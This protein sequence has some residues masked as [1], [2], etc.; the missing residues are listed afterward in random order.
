M[1]QNGHKSLTITLSTRVIIAAIVVVFILFTRLY[2]LDRKALMHDECMF[3]YYSWH[4]AMKGDYLYQPILH[5]PLLQNMNALMFIVLGDTTYMMRFFPA[6]CGILLFVVLYG[7]RERFDKNGMTALLVLAALSPFLMFY[8]RF[9][10]NDIPFALFSLLILFFYWKFFREGGGKNLIFAI[11][12]SVTLICI[13]EN[14]LI[15]FFTIFTFAGLLFL[16]DIIQGFTENKRLK[17]GGS[18]S[19]FENHAPVIPVKPLPVICLAGGTLITMTGIWGKLA[20]LRL[21]GFVGLVFYFALMLREYSRVLTSDKG[22]VNSAGPCMFIIAMNALAAVFFCWVLYLDL[23]SGLFTLKWTILRF[24]ALY[25]VWFVFFL[26]IALAMLRDWGREKLLK[27]FV[28]SLGEHYPYLIAGLAFSCVLYLVLFTTWFKYPKN[29]LLLYKETFEYWVGQHKEHRISGPFHYYLP[30]LA[31]YDLP[32]LLIIISGAFATLLRYR[33]VRRI[34][35]PLYAVICLLILMYFLK[36]PLSEKAWKAIYSIFHMTT[37]FHLFL[38]AT[39]SVMGTLLTVLHL[40]K[41]DRLKAFL[42]YWS[43]GSFLGYAYAGEK[44]PW[45]AVHIA[46]PLVML[47]AAYIQDFMKTGAFLR[48][49]GIWYAVFCLFAVWNL[50]SAVIVSFVNHSNIAERM[51]YSHA[52]EDVPLIAEQVKRISFE[53]G[54]REQTKILVKGWSIWPMRWYLRHY[55]WSEW[56]KPE[57]T[58]YPI[59]IMDYKD[60]M[61]IPNLTD[62]YHIVKHRVIQ[63]WVPAMIDFKSLSDIWK[64]TI[65]RQYTKDQKPYQDDIRMS[66]EEWKKIRKYL[67]HRE[68][69]EGKDSKWPS[70]SRPEIAVCVRKN[71]LER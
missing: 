16:V 3:A 24:A 42:I 32:V 18:P 30:I 21:L 55:S 62:N 64:L 28:I 5:G 50:K 69:F 15:Y 47:A 51:I 31:V 6:L 39:V 38:F 12:S 48:K 23:F 63:W 57:T 40:W 71:L 33:A 22:R 29:P 35:L 52:P 8:S 2:D 61:K 58:D 59:V 45:V 53:L 44:V 54:T 34:V 9:C 49:P 56:E 60:A 19:C 43:M 37:L 17:Y 14:Q 4:L 67:T 41:K 13:K 70:I 27:R 7:F 66:L 10:R 65:P 68:P 11:L 25:L 26:V 20:D 36:N 1:E 46:L